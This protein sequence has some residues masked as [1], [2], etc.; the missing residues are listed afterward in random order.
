MPCEF[1]GFGNGLAKTSDVL[2]Y[3]VA[4]LR[5]RAGQGRAG[6]SPSEVGV[7]WD[8]CASDKETNTVG[9]N[10]WSRR[11]ADTSP[12]PGRTKTCAWEQSVVFWGKG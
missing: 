3:D 12:C 6:T 7:F 11:P 5:G 1:V 9:R 2:G 10:V 8:N 4:L